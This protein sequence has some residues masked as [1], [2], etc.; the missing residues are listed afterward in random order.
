[1]YVQLANVLSQD[2]TKLCS[3]CFGFIGILECSYQVSTANI[4]MYC[5]SKQFHFKAVKSSTHFALECK[6]CCEHCITGRY[7]DRVP[8]NDAA[9]LLPVPIDFRRLPLL[10]SAERRLGELLRIGEASR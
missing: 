8:S 7:L 5:I 4:H 6:W 2:C 10:N 3:P 1:M 9:K